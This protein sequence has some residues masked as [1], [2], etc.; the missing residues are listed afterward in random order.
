M[1]TADVPYYAVKDIIDNPVN[2][3]TG[4]VINNDEKYAHPQY[5]TT[6]SNWDV[7]K[8]N[9][10]RFDDSDGIWYQVEGDIFLPSNWKRST[11]E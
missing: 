4:K 1:T 7:T 11:D 8:N 10:N 9:G 2:P 3:Y 6:S 5:I